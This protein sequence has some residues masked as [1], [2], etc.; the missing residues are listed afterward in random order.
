MKYPPV[1]EQYEIPGNIKKRG[2]AN[3]H[4]Q[5]TRLSAG[6]LQEYAYIHLN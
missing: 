5:N 2:S 1:L 3:M 4:Q 6:V